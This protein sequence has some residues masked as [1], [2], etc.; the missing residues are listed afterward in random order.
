MQGL[1]M[2]FSYPSQEDRQKRKKPKALLSDNGESNSMN[3]MMS[4]LDD[5]PADS[6]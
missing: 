2:G 3:D 4:D 1:I 5:M 6:P